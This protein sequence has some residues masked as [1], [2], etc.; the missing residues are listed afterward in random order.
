[1]KKTEERTERKLE[2]LEKS[3]ECKREK[4]LEEFEEAKYNVGYANSEIFT[5]KKIV[6]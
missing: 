3:F 2:L 6:C 1:M 4:C 5:S